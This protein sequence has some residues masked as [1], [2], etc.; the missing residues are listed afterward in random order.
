MVTED[1][2]RYVTKPSNN[3][4][5][6]WG[7]ARFFHQR[8]DFGRLHANQLRADLSLVERIVKTK[9]DSYLQLM[10]PSRCSS[11]QPYCQ[12]LMQEPACQRGKLRLRSTE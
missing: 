4:D 12:R 1:G 6:A 2:T 10:E 3:I 11:A 8:G 9:I 5:D 7:E